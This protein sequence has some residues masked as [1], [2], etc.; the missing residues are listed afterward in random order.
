MGGQSVIPTVP[1]DGLHRKIQE[2]NYQLEN[3]TGM[4]SH[5]STWGEFRLS[6]DQVV[7]DLQEQKKKID[8]LLKMIK[9]ASS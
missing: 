5:V 8:K 7:Q 2:E 6:N 3:F 1:C 9:K 4:L